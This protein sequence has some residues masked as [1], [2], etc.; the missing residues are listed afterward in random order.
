MQ[1]FNDNW[2]GVARNRLLKEGNFSLKHMGSIP[3]GHRLT[4]NTM[5]F[6]KT[7]DI[8]GT[9]LIGRIEA[10]VDDLKKV[11]GEPHSGKSSDGKSTI[12]WAFKKNSVVFTVYDYKNPPKSNTAKHTF[13]LG[14]KK[15]QAY[16]IQRVLKIAGLKS[17]I[18]RESLDDHYDDDNKN[19]QPLNESQ[20]EEFMK[21]HLRDLERIYDKAMKNPSRGNL[22]NTVAVL[23]VI[24]QELKKHM[25]SSRKS[26]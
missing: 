23:G 9:H 21:D 18:V 7:N 10:S 5:G 6:V 20:H 3:S 16:N 22:L 24:T 13:S 19:T 11:L 15:D 4:L 2:D 12:G 26:G 1:S 17:I 25:S 8:G 14:G